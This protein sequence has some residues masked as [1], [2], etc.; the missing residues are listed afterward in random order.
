MSRA[1]MMAAAAPSA[2]SADPMMVSGSLDVRTWRE[3]SSAQTT[4]TTA[5]GSASQNDLA[6]RSA[7]K[8]A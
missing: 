6:A 7:G 8:A 4:S 5:S 2:N 3:Q 1:L